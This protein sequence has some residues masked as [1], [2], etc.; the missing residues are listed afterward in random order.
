M[1]GKRSIEGEDREID[2]YPGYEGDDGQF[3]EY[4]QR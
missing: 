1:N 2:G 4:Y 3:G